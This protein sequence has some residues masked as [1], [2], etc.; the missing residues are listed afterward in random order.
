MLTVA[1]IAIVLALL[2][3]VGVFA[4]MAKD[5]NRRGQSGSQNAA[6]S[7]KQGRAAGPN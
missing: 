5:Q 6:G 3:L 4:L 7:A 1:F 2:A